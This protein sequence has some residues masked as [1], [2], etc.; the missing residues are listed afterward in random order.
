MLKACT[1]SIVSAFTYKGSGG[2][3]AGVVLDADGMTEGQMQRIATSVGVSE[4][5]FVSRS[6]IGAFRLDFFTPNMRIPHCG[7]ATIAAF[8]YLATLGRVGEGTTS[9]ET[10]DGLRQIEIRAGKP[11]MEQLAPIYDESA[12]WHLRSTSEQE[13]L[14]SL[15]LGRHQLH[16]H[17]GPVVVS[18][19]NRF[20][21]VGVSSSE[22]LRGV[23]PRLDAVE[24]VSRQLDLIGYYVY[25]T[26]TEDSCFDA[27]TRMFAPRYAIRE[28]AATG[29]AAGPLACLL[30]DRLDIR[31]RCFS[32]EQGGMMQP[33]SRSHLVV[34]LDIQ[35][36]RITGLSVGGSGQLIRRTTAY[37]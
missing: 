7:H 33:P 22:V 14:H 30:H 8:Y 20:L 15:G 18:T 34:E 2:N 5:A 3:L 10:V 28:E 35:S 25:A 4:T 26:E 17:S 23:M 32:I 16:R 31:K 36:D 27:S 29:M 12:D 21:L 9:K 11:Y 37:I 1:V 6:D 24:R 13:V 19:G